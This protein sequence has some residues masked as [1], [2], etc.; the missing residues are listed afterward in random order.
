VEEVI[1]RSRFITTLGRARDVEEAREFVRTVKEEF[2]DANHN[3]WAYVAGPPGDTAFIGMSDEG[4]PHG[5]AGRPMLTVLLHGEVGE[6]V[7]VVTRFFGGVKLGKGGLVRAYSSG[8]QLALQSVP[9]VARVERVR[10][11]IV[12]EY[13]VADAVRRLLAGPGIVMR[14]EEYGAQVCF[15]AGVPAEALEGLEREVAGATRGQGA[16]E[17]VGPEE[18]DG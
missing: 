11:R 4:E 14:V 10:V 15:E 3:C 16:F 6:V 9:T 12:V 17:T 13:P 7:A 5:T 8:V 1:Q 18:D 2:P